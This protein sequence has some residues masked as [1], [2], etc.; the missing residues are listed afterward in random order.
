M[1]IVDST[2]MCLGNPRESLNNLQLVSQPKGLNSSRSKASFFMGVHMSV[3]TLSH[4]GTL[5]QLFTWWCHNSVC[6]S[7]HWSSRS[8]RAGRRWLSLSQFRYLTTSLPHT[9]LFTQSIHWACILMKWV[10]FSSPKKPSSENLMSPTVSQPKFFLMKT[11]RNLFSLLGHFSF[12][13][14]HFTSVFGNVQNL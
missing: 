14:C 5:S 11:R 4:T 12:E 3:P 10:G 7:L 13:V 9:N 8:L 2:I 6:Q 1:V